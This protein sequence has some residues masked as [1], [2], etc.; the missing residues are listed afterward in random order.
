MQRTVEEISDVSVL[1]AQ[2]RIVVAV[3]VVLQGRVSVWRRKW[4]QRTV[5][6][7][8]DLAVP[9]V[10]KVLDGITA[11]SQERLCER[12]CGRSMIFSFL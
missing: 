1:Q 9:Q 4:K 6:Q 10:K 8:V 5:D 2:E 12:F 3:K 7:L 11:F